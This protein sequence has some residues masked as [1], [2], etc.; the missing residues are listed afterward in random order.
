MWKL[1]LA[2]LIYSSSVF[3]DDQW[4]NAQCEHCLPLTVNDVQV[5]LPI[6]GLV[7]SGPGMGG[8]AGDLAFVAIYDN[9]D[10]VTI[11]RAGIDDLVPGLLDSE[12]FREE[13]HSC[14]SCL[15]Q[16]AVESPDLDTTNELVGRVVRAF[17]IDT[18]RS[19]SYRREDVTAVWIPGETE[20]GIRSDQLLVQRQGSEKVYLMTGRFNHHLAE[21]VLASL[22]YL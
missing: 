6:D 4:P 8:G 10:Q 2:L 15:M 14:L 20:P 16:L 11:L 5:M 17:E 19:K 22:R 18:D 3:A 7:E 13:Y 12:Q 9:A 21:R 1:S